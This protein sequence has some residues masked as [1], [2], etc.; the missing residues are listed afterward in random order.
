MGMRNDVQGTGVFSS[1][2][3]HRDIDSGD[4]G[5]TENNANTGNGMEEI[6]NE[7]RDTN[8]VENAERFR[9]FVQEKDEKTQAK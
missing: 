8:H 6:P 3:L 2:E 7:K 5:N 1:F 9:D 4:T